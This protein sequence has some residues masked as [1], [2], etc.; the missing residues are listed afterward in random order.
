LRDTLPSNTDSTTTAESTNI[1]ADPSAATNTAPS[2]ED[3]L[4]E[5]QERIAF[6]ATELQKEID[7]R[8]SFETELACL[9]AQQS[10]LAKPRKPDSFSGN[11]SSKRDARLWLHSMKHYLHQCH[12]PQNEWV[13]LTITYLEGDAAQWWDSEIMARGGQVAFMD[14]AEFESLFLQRFQ[15]IPLGQINYMKIKDWRHT[16]SLETYVNGF[17]AMAAAVPYSLFPEEARALTFIHN[18]KPEL[19]KLVS[20]QN[21]TTIR[22]AISIAQKVDGFKTTTN[23]RVNPPQNQRLTFSRRS[24]IVSQGDRRPSSITCN[25]DEIGS[26]SNGKQLNAIVT[27]ISNEESPYHYLLSQLTEEQK[28]LMQENRCFKCKQVGHRLSECRKRKRESEFQPALN[29]LKE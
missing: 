20:S 27:D 13:N 10:N 14:W 15:P 2:L 23:Y 22:E 26:Y 9:R 5:A 21:P 3:Q 28:R 19:G 4:L 24:S 11:Q 6:A 8:V 12:T 29:H 17:L 7:R 18:L 16:G 25:N 1:I